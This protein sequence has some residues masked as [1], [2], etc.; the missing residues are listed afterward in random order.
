MNVH[1]EKIL[2]VGEFLHEMYAKA[3]YKAFQEKKYV[4]SLFSTGQSYTGN[5]I[6]DFFTKAQHR[7]LIGPQIYNINKN[8]L[9]VTKEFKPD[10]VFLYRT[11]SINPK[12]VDKIKKTGTIVFSYNNDDPFSRIPSLGYWRFYINSTKFCHHNFVYRS[13]NLIDFANLGVEN[14]SVLKSYYIKENNFWLNKKKNQDV[15]FIGHFENDG[16]DVYIKEL[17][18]AEIKVVVYGDK[19][20]REAPLYNEIKCAIKDSKRGKEYNDTLNSAKIALVFLSKINSDNY[21]RRC[22]EIPATKTLMLS[23][24][25]FELT[26]MYEENV[27]AVYFRTK[28]ELVDKC[29][30]LLKDNEMRKRISVNGFNRLIE[31]SNEVNDRIDE[32]MKKFSEIK[33]TI[34]I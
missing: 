30:L 32:I 23:Q 21:T 31:S 9:K 3:F 22:F 33:N 1:N 8:L 11:P 15:V 28:E 27:E 18:D 12:T 17:L 19:F 29:K 10:L 2:V 25:S 5:L 16:R 20:W 13:K 14:V 4:V 7:F 34:K 26:L 6:L 24:F